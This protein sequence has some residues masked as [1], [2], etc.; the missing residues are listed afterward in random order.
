M[1]ARTAPKPE[2]TLLSTAMQMICGAIVLGIAAMCAGDTHFSLQPLMRN[3][4]T[5]TAA[6]NLLYNINDTEGDSVLGVIVSGTATASAQSAKISATIPATISAIIIVVVVVRT[7]T[8][9]W[10]CCG[11]GRQVVHK[12]IV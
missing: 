3:R 11:G 8:R 5:L 7:K 12:F 10:Q 4:W 6:P 9:V 1:L 2:S